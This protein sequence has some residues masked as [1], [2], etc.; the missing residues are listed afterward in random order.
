MAI[1]YIEQELNELHDRRLKN[2]QQRIDL[3]KNYAKIE[4]PT[5]EQQ[6]AYRGTLESLNK[7]F[8]HM[9]SEADSYKHY[10]RRPSGFLTKYV[11]RLLGPLPYHM[12]I[13]RV[14]KNDEEFLK[15]V[16]RVF[17]PRAVLLVI[18]VAVVAGIGHLIHPILNES[19]LSMTLGTLFGEG[20]YH[21]LVLM[22]VL[23]SALICFVVNKTSPG[24]I[25]T[26]IM[27]R[28]I[29]NTQWLRSGSK[30][31]SHLQRVISCVSFGVICMTFLIFPFSMFPLFVLVGYVAMFYE[32]LFGDEMVDS[33]RALVSSHLV[34]KTMTYITYIVV[35][36]ATINALFYIF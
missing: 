15:E 27:R 7:N 18:M 21:I 14:H 34:V 17:A 5:V 23:V 31:W 36:V 19:P 24:R 4:N 25:S 29:A 12:R 32:N 30:E 16:S 26:F 3:S 6:I 1:D 28:A 9:T 11:S 13:V 20:V 35:G 33:T 22:T 10:Y 2:V 8:K